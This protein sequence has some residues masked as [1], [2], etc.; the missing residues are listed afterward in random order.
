MKKN[1]VIELN[2]KVSQE[3]LNEKEKFASE[4][5]KMESELLES[6]FE[7]VHSSATFEMLRKR[8]SFE[9][10]GMTQQGKLNT[11]E[12][13]ALNRMYKELKE[14]VCKTI[15]KRS[16]DEFKFISVLES[17]NK[18][19]KDETF[20]SF[21][22]NKNVPFPIVDKIGRLIEGDNVLNQ[23]LAY[24]I[25]RLVVNV[26]TYLDLP[27]TVKIV[28]E[29]RVPKK[30]GQ[31]SKKRKSGVKYIYK[32]IYKVKEVI[33]PVGRQNKEREYYKETWERK[34]HKRVYRNKITGEITKEVW[35]KPV[36]C[37]AKGKV[38]ENQN[39][40]ITKIN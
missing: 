22:F 24:G 21:H 38:K 39:L 15:I 23:E 2:R 13:R 12:Y 36:M 16:D 40:K 5:F 18:S 17:S 3:L 11:A 8:I 32:T 6:G 30:V 37:H 27:T 26:V 14:N 34:G 1:V 10:M 9:L 31:G 28:D 19:I 25:M 29:V 20:I 35:I 33:N 7:L 4:I